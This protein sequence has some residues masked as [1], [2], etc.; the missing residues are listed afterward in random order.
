M[1]L[2][3]KMEFN[4][5]AITQ[6]LWNNIMFN[7]GMFSRGAIT[8]VLWNNSLNMGNRGATKRRSSI[9]AR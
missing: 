1:I 8:Q 2:T 4:R 3:T 7:S 9:E 5:G 6:V